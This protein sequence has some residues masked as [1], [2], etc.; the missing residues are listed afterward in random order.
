M[1]I[2]KSENKSRTMDL[3]QGPIFSRLMV[4]ALPLLA[5]QVFQTLYNSV[6]SIVIGNFEG[7]NALAAVTASGTIS[8]IIIGFF[9]GMSAGSTAVF[10][11]QFGAKQFKTLHDAI[12][13]TVLFSFFM[14]IIL[15]VAGV[16]LTPQLLRITA[17]PREVF[18]EALIYLRIY[19]IGVFFTSIYN[20]GASVLRAIGDSRSPFIFL[21]ISSCM[22]IV[23]DIILVAVIPLGVAGV[24]IA[25]VISQGASMILVFIKMMRL[26]DEYRLRFSHL[27][28]DWMLLGEIVR[29][30]LP[31]GI[32][33]SITAVSNL[34]VQRYINS[35]SPLAIAG[36]G[37]AM[38]VDQFAGMPCAALGLAMTTFIGQNLG[39]GRNDRA[40]KSVGVATLST[41]VFVAVISAPI[42]LFA[43]HLIRIFSPD[44][45][46]IEYG[47]AMLKII[48]PLYIFMGLNFLYGGIVRG[49]RYS[50][51]SMFCTVGGM[52]V[53][54][55]LWLA[56]MLNIVAHDISYVFY[57]YPIGWGTTSLSL[58]LV[59]L[60]KIR[61][62]YSA[63]ANVK[64]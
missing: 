56:I 29:M 24:A 27:M 13:T 21:V 64:V 33:S 19:L 16:A 26:D 38:R 35:F 57:C 2:V 43:P 46:V 37:A 54:R 61:Q 25:T 53:I 42:Y 39:A 31:A 63:G 48:M 50:F 11:R 58:I 32:Q 41:I 4:F 52:V 55:Q 23:L 62:K 7:A 18:D 5:G 40:H 3:S 8:M 45:G 28:I 10:S 60:L 34:F 30:G 9:N 44:S 47:A 6:D 36:V 14:G 15:A 49:F 22:N 51:T 20:T 17:C 1:S 59:Y 12:H